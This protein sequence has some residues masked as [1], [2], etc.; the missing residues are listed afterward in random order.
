MTKENAQTSVD[1]H[2]IYISRIFHGNFSPLEN[3]L[4][5]KNQTHKHMKIDYFFVTWLTL[6]YK[7]LQLHL[8]LAIYHYLACFDI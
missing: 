3:C 4:Y 8:V 6:T 7:S 2:N 1:L 5:N